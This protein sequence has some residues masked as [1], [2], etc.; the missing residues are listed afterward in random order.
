MTFICHGSY[1]LNG[2]TWLDHGDIEAGRAILQ[3]TELHRAFTTPFGQTGFYR[4]VVT[5]LHSIDHMLYA[6]WAPGYHLTNIFL[7]LLV[8]LG[9]IMFTKT[10]F[11]LERKECLL[12]GMLVGAH[13]LSWL[14]VGAIAYRQET[15]A[16]FFVL[17]AGIF[18]VR[19]RKQGSIT[20]WASSLL[21][22]LVALLS[23]ESAAVWFI[24]LVLLWELQS[25]GSRP[26]RLR[27]R[28]VSFFATEL[29]VLAAYLVLRTQMLGGYWHLNSP[30]LD[31]TTLFYTQLQAIARQI[32]E[33]ASPLLPQLS[34]ATPICSH[35]CLP[36]V[37]GLLYCL[38]GLFVTWRYG[39]S[40][41][42]GF[43][44]ALLF[45]SLLPTLK[46]VALPRF[47]SPHYAYFAT[48]P[49]SVA[50]VLL[51]KGLA[52]GSELRRRLC[53]FAVAGWIGIACI[54]TFLGGFRFKNDETLFTAEV[55][56]DPSFREGAF[57][58][59]DFWQQRG[60][61]DK[62]EVYYKQALREDPA[63]LAYVDYGSLLINYAGLMVMAGRL[64][65]ADELLQASLSVAPTKELRNIAYNRALIAYKRYDFARTVELLTPYLD[66]FS[67]PE[68]RRLYKEALSKLKPS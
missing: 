41:R 37:L 5:I 12:V 43:C 10:S 39:L 35:L 60:D 66:T 64:V 44:L 16:V 11:E 67:R 68:P 2:F 24:G 58:L 15:L 26:N 7:H 25:D 29:F 8:V 34:D 49:F 14:P 65:E 1:F 38:I 59:A 3:P 42:I 4:P 46:F 20:A 40:S 52:V 22:L 36:A 33:L 53:T 18:H 13:P 32:G 47:S 19:F 28:T 31:S 62:A 48:I 51:L 57:Y 21:A 54:S 55:N 61:P 23:K 63:V 45:V 27:A 50:L 17:L 30:P 56:H 6:Q 9:S